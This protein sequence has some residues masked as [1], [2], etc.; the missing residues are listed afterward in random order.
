MRESQSLRENLARRLSE[1]LER[2]GRNQAPPESPRA[3]QGA[4]DEQ[5]GER[6]PAQEAE[7]EEE[8]TA[9]GPYQDEDEPRTKVPRTDISE[10]QMA[11]QVG[12]RGPSCRKSWHI[13]ASA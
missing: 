9:E 6:Q 5:G 13:E 11:P 12:T 4:E 8:G 7:G 2:Q 3:E 1:F 10:L